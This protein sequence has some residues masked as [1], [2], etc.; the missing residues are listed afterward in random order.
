MGTEDAFRA[1]WR[2]SYGTPP[3]PHAVMTHVAWSQ[4]VMGRPPMPPAELV[5]EWSAAASDGG[6]ATLDQAEQRI[7]AMAIRWAWNHGQT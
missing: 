5:A 6:N 2:G 4:H 3:G 7:A 1:W